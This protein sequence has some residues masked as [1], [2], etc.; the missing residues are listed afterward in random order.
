MS[1][2][3]YDGEAAFPWKHTATSESINSLT[4]KVV[5]KGKFEETYFPGM[6]LRDYFSAKALQGLCSIEDERVCPKE[7]IPDADS[8]R[9]ELFQVDAQYCYALADAM[10]LERSKPP[11]P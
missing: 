5:E 9:R 11:T 4:G 2:K 7:R 8:W 1:D 10:L 6:S 3:I